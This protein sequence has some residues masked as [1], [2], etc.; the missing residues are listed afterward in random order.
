MNIF[1]V[2]SE[3]LE[4]TVLKASPTRLVVMT[5]DGAIK[6]LESSIDMIGKGD[7][8][9]RWRSVE[10]ATDLISDLYMNLDHDQGGEVAQNLGCLYGFILS[11][12]PRINFYNDKQT[13]LDAISILKRL[14][15]SFDELDHQIA[16]NADVAISGNSGANASVA[17]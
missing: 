4:Q 14:R 8:E 15:D 6:C 1:N 7:I 9:G 3:E 11:N 5:Y 16:A 12:L 17:L 13:A 2:A 10:K